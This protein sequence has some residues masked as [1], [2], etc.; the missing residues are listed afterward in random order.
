MIRGAAPMTAAAALAGSELRRF[1]RQP[2]RLI[3]TLGAP[4]LVWAFLG[5]GFARAVGL[6]GAQE[7]FAAF[8]LPGALTL[9][10][11]F[12]S[13]FAAISLI[14]DRASGLLQSVLAGPTA[15]AT[16]ALGKTLGGSVLC[17]AQAALLL[18]LAWMV[19]LSPTPV[20]VL[21]AVAVL[22]C[23][24]IG[25]SGLCLALAW[26]IDSTS[27]FH[28]IMNLVLMPMWLLSGAV[29]PKES[30]SGW[31]ASVV[32]V[33]PLTWPTDALRTLLAGETPGAVAIV[34]A[35]GFALLGA[36]VAYGSIGRRPRSGNATPTHREP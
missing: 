33:N 16:V 20:H 36:V 8:A 21:A 19:G 28:G 14:E 4:L 35:A 24:A 3:A 10:V 2:S 27:G 7:G 5:A 32:A 31:M 22:A 12:G 6:P 34:G 11:L 18:P 25:I 9:V 30:A 29:V 15:P 23:I 1:A 26:I 13:V 17:L